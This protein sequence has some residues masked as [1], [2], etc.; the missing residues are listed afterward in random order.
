MSRLCRI[1][2]QS[3]LLLSP[4]E[5][6]RSRPVRIV[7]VGVS[8]TSTQAPY[9]RVCDSPRSTG[10]R[11]FS[12][13]VRRDFARLTVAP[14]RRESRPWPGSPPWP[15]WVTARSTS[16]RPRRGSGVLQTA[17]PRIDLQGEVT[18]AVGDHGSHERA[19]LGGP[20]VHAGSPGRIG[21]L[22]G[23]TVQNIPSHRRGSSPTPHPPVH[24]CRSGTRA[25]AGRRPCHRARG[26]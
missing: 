17:V 21:Q 18:G 11:R 10:T 6:E 14:P 15:S 13:Q 9:G 26:P 25:A 2:G 5:S 4:R 12:R 7:W 22:P 1:D 16:L 3:L 24:S 23:A 20:H 19:I 8:S